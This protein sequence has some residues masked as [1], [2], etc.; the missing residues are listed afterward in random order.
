MWLC[1]GHERDEEREEGRNEDK[2][3]RFFWKGS[4][5]WVH[6]CPGESDME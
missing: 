1:S 2:A 6:W 4:V 5:A 3:Y